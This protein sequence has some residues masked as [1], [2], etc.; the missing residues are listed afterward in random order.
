M[1]SLWQTI[2]FESN[3]KSDWAGYV[4]VDRQTAGAKKYRCSGIARVTGVSMRWL[5]TYVNTKYD[6]IPRQVDVWPK[7]RGA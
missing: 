2:C 4:V 6:A 5:Q 1:Q 7:K 3:Q